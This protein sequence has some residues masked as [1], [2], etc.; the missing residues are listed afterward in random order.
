ME[1]VRQ[2]NQDIFESLTALGVPKE[3]VLRFLISYRFGSIRKFSKQSKVSHTSILQAL[4]GNH[5][6]VR[7]IISHNLFDNFNPF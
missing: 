4:K 1:G 7:E 2:N 6:N 3:T 5:K